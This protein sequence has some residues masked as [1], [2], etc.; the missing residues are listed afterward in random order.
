[1]PPQKPSHLPDAFTRPYAEIFPGESTISFGTLLTLMSPGTSTLGP[2]LVTKKTRET[3]TIELI[4][5]LIMICR[6]NLRSPVLST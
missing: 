5:F 3:G 1:M 2:Q 6:F 4:N